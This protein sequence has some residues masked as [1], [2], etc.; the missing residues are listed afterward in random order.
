MQRE[1][2]EIRN[3]VGLTSGKFSGWIDQALRSTSF[4][5]VTKQGIV[6]SYFW[7][8]AK[9]QLIADVPTWLGA[10]EKA[11]AAGETEAKAVAMADQAVLDSQGGGQVKDLARIQRG[12]P[13]LKLWT[14]FYSYFNVTWGRTVESVLRTNYRDPVSVGRL[15]VDFLM[16][17]TVPATMGALMRHALTGGGDDELA[18]KLI[19]ENLAYM[20]GMLVGVRELGSLAGGFT[21]YGGPAGARV[22]VALHKLGRQ[23]EQGEL[24][25]AFWRALNDSAGILLHYPAGQVRRTVEGYMALQ[26]GRTQNPMALVVGAPK[27]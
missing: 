16:L 14:N 5:H 12:G 26:E 21:E 11:M 23:I 25:A 1:I 19:R 7:L 24:D 4:D 6:D 3:R 8:I 17:Y 2:N 9:A 27:E 18:E 13:M 22:F 10:Y 20:A 15:A